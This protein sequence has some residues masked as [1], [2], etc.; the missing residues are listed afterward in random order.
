VASEWRAVKRFADV[1]VG[2]T[3]RLVRPYTEIPDPDESGGFQINERA[4]YE[5]VATHVNPRGQ[6]NLAG[7]LTFLEDAT[8]GEWFYE[9]YI[10]T[11]VNT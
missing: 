7:H 9:V 4:A 6:I 10:W 2:D 5:G 1:K 3:V 8:F 11:E